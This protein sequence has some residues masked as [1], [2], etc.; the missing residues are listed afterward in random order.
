MHS[1]FRNN[2]KTLVGSDEYIAFIV[3]QKIIS[4]IVSQTFPGGK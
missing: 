3:C 4:G 1:M 2:S